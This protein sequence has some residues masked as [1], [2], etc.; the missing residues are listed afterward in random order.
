MESES[1]APYGSRKCPAVLIL[2]L[3]PLILIGCAG[4]KVTDQ[5]TAIPDQA[6]EATIAALVAQNAVLA[7]QVAELEKKP[8][9]PLTPEPM[10]VAEI[11][12]V[13]EEPTPVPATSTAPPPSATPTMPASTPTPFTPTPHVASATPLSPTLT[14]E[15][16]TPTPLPPE[17][18][19]VPTTAQPAPVRITFQPGATSA[20][21][22][23]RLAESGADQYVV[24]A[25]ADQLLDVSVSPAKDTIRL[26]IHGADG[27]V[28]EG[29][30]TDLPLLRGTL[31]KTQDYLISVAS[32]GPE[33][34]YTL[35]VII[36]RRITF[37]PGGTSAL[38]EG[39]LTPQ[40]GDYYVIRA[41]SEQLLD[42]TVRAPDDAAQ[43]V[44]YGVD[45]TVLKSGM[46][47]PTGFRGILPTT[48]DYLLRVSSN[49]QVTYQLEVIIPQRIVFAPG[50]TSATLESYLAAYDTD[51][52]VIRVMAGQLMEIS[53]D[54]PADAVR[55]VVYGVD[56]TVLKSGMGGGAIYLGTVP[57]TQDYL[58][59]VSTNR[60]LTYGLRVMIPS[61][62][63]FEPGGTSANVQASLAA[64]QAHQ[65]VIRAASG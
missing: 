3:I 41:I 62:I 44:T 49:R 39:V 26:H 36:P 5:P 31:P 24:R 38:V 57:V 18:T 13:S 35:S 48:Q 11:T 17:A 47:E 14:P 40:R 7:T 46:G 45:G 19:P 25:V 63:T 9:T 8:L 1:K 65:Y 37:Q 23:G 30:G 52:Y 4:P 10:A 21:I 58:V 56:G 50:G 28:L 27:T 6:T 16:P 20:S 29:D 55:L 43:L 12:P 42:I 22:V 33:M 51:Y 60:E 54:G 53:V 34:N 64:N 15:P 2:L 32:D 61:R 59:N